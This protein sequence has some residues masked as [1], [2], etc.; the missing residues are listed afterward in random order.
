MCCRCEALGERTGSPG[1]DAWNVSGVG[2]RYVVFRIVLLF[3]YLVLIL[4]T[5][6]PMKWRRTWS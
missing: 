2:S 3:A 5:L 1:L 6:C 4:R